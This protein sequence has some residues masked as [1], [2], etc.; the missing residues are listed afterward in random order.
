MPRTIN[1]TPY[2]VNEPDIDYYFFNHNNWKGQCDDK[3]FLGIDQESF[4][5]VNNIYIDAEGV[6]KTRP[7]VID[8]I[9]SNLTNKKVIEVQSFE[10]ILVIKN[11]DNTTNKYYYNFYHDEVYKASGEVTENSKI[12][13]FDNKLFIFTGRSDKPYAYY[14]L[15]N[16]TYY[17]D[18]S[19]L[20]YIP[21]IN[22]YTLDGVTENE[23]KN[24][25]TNSYKETIVYGVVGMPS[26]AIGRDLYYYINDSYGKTRI[27]ISQY[28][29]A[30]QRYLL[31]YKY[32]TDYFASTMRAC[33][34][35]YEQET[36]V[37]VYPTSV[38]I[39]VSYANDGS[40]IKCIMKSPAPSKNMSYETT[41]ITYS[42]DGINFSAVKEFPYGK[43]AKL[44]LPK[45]SQD[46][47]TVF[48]FLNDEGDT[49]PVNGTDLYAITVGSEITGAIYA[50]WTLIK[51]FDDTN[52]C[53][54]SFD[55]TDKN[56][57]VL[58]MSYKREG[59]NA[60]GFVHYFF[61][62]ST[63]NVNTRR[64]VTGY[65]PYFRTYI[66]NNLVLLINNFQL[67]DTEVGK[68]SVCFFWISSSSLAQGGNFSIIIPKSNN[69]FQ[70]FPDMM[71][72]ALYYDTT[73]AYTYNGETYSYLV[74]IPYID[75]N[76]ICHLLKYFCK[77]DDISKHN[78]EDL[79]L[80]GMEADGM[81]QL[82]YID[83]ILYCN[84]YIITGNLT[85]GFNFASGNIASN[86]NAFVLSELSLLLPST[87]IFGGKINRQDVVTNKLN[88]NERIK[89][90]SVYNS[91]L[92][93]VL[94]NYL[95]TLNR[96][97]IAI[98]NVTYIDDA[99]END[100]LTKK[101]L[102]FPSILSK[103]YDYDVNALH[104]I[105]TSQMG[106]FFDDSVWIIQASE[107]KI[108]D[109]NYTDYLH[110]KSQVSVGITKG[111]DVITSYDGKYVIFATQRG[112]VSMSYQDFVASTDQSLSYLSDTILVP[113]VE[114][115]KN[116][117]IKLYM[118]RYWLICYKQGSDTLYVMD[119]RNNSWWLMTYVKGLT[120]VCT[121]DYK[122]LLVS[123]NSIKV[124]DK[125]DTTCKDG[126]GKL[127]K[128]SLTSQKL[129]F[130]APNYYKHIYS[131]TISAVNDTEKPVSYLITIVNY[132]NTVNID[133]SDIMEYQVD[134]VRTY[135][136]RLNYSKVNEFQYI[137]YNSASAPSRLSV[138][139][140]TTKYTITSLAR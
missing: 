130:N 92:N 19:S 85:D 81:Y 25:L 51:H 69:K 16:D 57:F 72:C 77:E 123:D 62:G 47:T 68:L 139:N 74:Y 59:E 53:S 26:I 103:R 94:P 83:G 137:L 67:T 127:I 4:E 31:S 13:L 48:A 12:L 117:A 91:T 55:A 70:L 5:D 86:D 128:W 105:S 52:I 76:Y 45:L 43:T 54:I 22:T 29:E 14:N 101:L 49:L 114:Y 28:K 119:M 9:Y 65:Q 134:I 135:V 11:L 66:R 95:S 97:V 8:K 35:N 24:I 40:L 58:G 116:N 23:S 136:K 121:I 73:G 112:L 138:S 99:R 32:S 60:Y 104:P 120:S 126:N 102:Y 100:T 106:V 132:R 96:N 129:H 131:L 46:G 18:A 61:T 2:T 113:F 56:K 17:D 10:D 71:E 38:K 7:S 39:P 98:D 33:N 118:Y 110:T 1:R 37:P 87:N 115:C 44:C 3:N 34:A 82:S 41:S 79:E 108:T 140:I 125:D 93:N 30:Y 109:T 6:L 27:D 78:T 133:T 84:N 107:N 64:T 89:L 75:G 20:I 50:D 36:K 15:K 42:V 111:S 21:N 90:Y 80:Y 63:V 124:F 122:P 88:V